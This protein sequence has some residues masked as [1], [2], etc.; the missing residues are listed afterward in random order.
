METEP[1][2]SLNLRLPISFHAALKAA[3]KKKKRS[4][5]GEIIYRLEQSLAQD[6]PEQQ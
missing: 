6:D 2:K 5:Q 3:A 4:L 1:I